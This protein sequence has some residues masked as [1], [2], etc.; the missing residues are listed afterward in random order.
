[1]E[2]HINN[3]KTYFK[4]SPKKNIVIV[5]AITGLFV[6]S[7]LVSYVYHFY[8]GI[9]VAT[10]EVPEVEVITDASLPTLSPDTQMDILLIGYGGAGH[11]GGT[12]SDVLIDVVIDVEKK[13]VTLISIP[14]DLWV[15]IPISSDKRENYK[16]NTAYAIGSD[17]NKYPYKEPAYVGV[18]GGG[19]MSKSV[20]S[21]VIGRK[22]DHFVS[23]DF[24]QFSGAIDKI[25]GISVDVPHSFDDYFYPIKGEEQNLCGKSPEEMVRIHELYTGFSL[26][27]EFTCRYEH[28][29]FDKG[30]AD[31]DGATALKFVRS[32]HSEVNGGDFARSARQ[33]ALL[34]AI[35]DKLIANGSAKDIVNFSDSMRN[36]LKTD[37]DKEAVKKLV[38]FAGDPNSY[39]VKTVNVSTQNV[40]TDGRSPDG[41]A[42]VIPKAG[43]GNWGGIQGYIQ[44]E[45]EK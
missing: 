26:E 23:I 9:Y 11:E 43:D 45:M 42:I 37:M 15:T 41:Q 30:V 35:K 22:I 2:K 16:I 18:G 21:T 40:L 44:T 33:Q 10:N 6:L 8:T 4:L 13:Q 27:K 20:V 29:H 36:L 24:A 34:I 28:L 17:D 14:R 1:V 38:A 3:L 12:L 25:G 39:T 19:N 31:M 7:F 32:R 5:S